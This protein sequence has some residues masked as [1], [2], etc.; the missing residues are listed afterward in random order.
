MFEEPKRKPYQATV[1]KL[2]EAVWDR[3]PDGVGTELSD[4]QR[5]ELDRRWA[6]RILDV[7]SDRGA[8]LLMAAQRLTTYS[9]FRIYKANAIEREAWSLHKSIK[10]L[11][12]LPVHIASLGLPQ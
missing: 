12:S 6:E 11:P 8:V 4:S 5:A 2:L 7:G 1:A 10:I 9:R 3:L